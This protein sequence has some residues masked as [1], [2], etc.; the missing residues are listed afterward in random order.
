MQTKKHTYKEKQ[1]QKWSWLKTEDD[2]K[3]ED[4]LKIYDNPQW[5]S[6]NNKDNPIKEDNTRQEDDLEMVHPLTW[7]EANKWRV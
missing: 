2:P 5:C 1:P 3:N 4:I 7:R 6:L